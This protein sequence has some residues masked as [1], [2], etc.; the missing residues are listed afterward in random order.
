MCANL[1]LLARQKLSIMYRCLI[2]YRNV[3]HLSMCIAPSFFLL[4]DKGS[5]LF[6]FSVSFSLSIFPSLSFFL[7]FSLSFAVSLSHSLG[8]CYLL[9]PPSLL[10][11]YFWAVA[12]SGR[13]QGEICASIC[14][15]VH[16]SICLSICTSIPLFQCFS[17]AGPGPSELCPGLP[18]ASSGFSE[19]AQKFSEVPGE[20]TCSQH[21]FISVISSLVS[22]YALNYAQG[23]F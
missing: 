2:S 4:N 15:S 20:C 7:P 13:I 19:S 21:L 18:Q 23:F 11:I 9:L 8:F 3:K 17:E 5:F 10:F 16:P 6:I 22:I 14:L 1:E 12:K